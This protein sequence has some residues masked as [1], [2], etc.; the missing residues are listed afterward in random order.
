MKIYILVFFLIITFIHCSLTEDS[1]T[2]DIVYIIDEYTQ[3]RTEILDWL[4][5]AI[6]GME[7]V[8]QG[9]GVGKTQNPNRYGL[10]TFGSEDIPKASFFNDSFFTNYD[11]FFQLIRPLINSKPLINTLTDGY[12]AIEMALSYPYRIDATRFLIFVSPRQQDLYINPRFREYLVQRLLSEP[13]ITNFLLNVSYYTDVV[14]ITPSLLITTLGKLIMGENST[15]YYINKIDSNGFLKTI[16]NLTMDK[17]ARKQVVDNGF[18]YT[19]LIEEYLAKTLTNNIPIPSSFWDI[20]NILNRN[21][22]NSE[23][24]TQ[25]FLSTIQSLLAK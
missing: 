4:S 11:E 22:L 8:L 9:K 24:L 10:I 20:N 2:A 5:N 23:Y 6:S 17:L 19:E 25:A 3:T 16:W 18:D 14:P 7:Q 21:L 12:H 15:T 13:V 1:V